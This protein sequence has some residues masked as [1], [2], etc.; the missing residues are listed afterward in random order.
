[1]TTTTLAGVAAAA[2]AAAS[3]PPA[4]AADAPPAPPA[5]PAA[6]SFTQAQLDAAVAAAALKASADA[7]ARLSAILADDKV[8]G[9]ERAALDL[10]LKSPAMP[11]ADVVAF[12]DANV[13]GASRLDAVVPDPQ[14]AAD[15]PGARKPA[16]DTGAIYAARAK[17]AAGAA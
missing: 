15:A 10:A 3:A 9:R 14:V 11:A 5:P 6:A 13:R 17:S 12:V 1:M 16:I 4:P 7:H 8:K 2:L